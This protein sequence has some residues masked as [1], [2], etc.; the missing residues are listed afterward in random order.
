MSMT[1]LDANQVIRSSYDDSS[2]GLKTVNISSMISDPF[3]Y[4]EITYVPSGPGAGEISSVTYKSGGS[5]GTTIAVLT[6]GYDSGNNLTS[7]T[8]S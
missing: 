2:G 7:V 8:K 5:S 6:L 4:I 1:G 3:D